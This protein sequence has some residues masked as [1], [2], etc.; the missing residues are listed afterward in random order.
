MSDVLT[1]LEDKLPPGSER[2]IALIGAILSIVAFFI[3]VIHK[4]SGSSTGTAATSSGTT[5]TAATAS[6]LTS[7]S[8][9]ALTTLQSQLNTLQTTV[10]GL[11]TQS[12]QTP[13]SNINLSFTEDTGQLL[14][15]T[16][17]GIAQ[18]ASGSAGSAGL[19]IT[20][21]GSLGGSGS[22]TNSSLTQNQAGTAISTAGTFTSNVDL[23]NAM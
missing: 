7:G 9:S 16:L 12:T 17:S 5:G 10:T 8:T 2:H 20:G 14:S 1:K 18:S 11:Q 15:N 19:S 4:S 3:Y 6:G 23:V 22:S 21:L 13:A